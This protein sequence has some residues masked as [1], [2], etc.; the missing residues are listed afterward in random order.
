MR[1]VYVCDECGDDMCILIVPIYAGNPDACPLAPDE[2]KWRRV[3]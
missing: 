1:K 3:E 2:A